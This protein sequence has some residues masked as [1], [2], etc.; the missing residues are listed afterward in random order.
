[1]CLAFS[2]YSLKTILSHSFVANFHHQKAA[3]IQIQADFASTQIVLADR[4]FDF[5][6]QYTHQTVVAIAFSEHI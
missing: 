5:N 1:M 3:L 4:M 6:T 2:I